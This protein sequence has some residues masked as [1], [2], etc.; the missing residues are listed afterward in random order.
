[1]LYGWDGAM[2]EAGGRGFD[3]G[4]FFV[5]GAHLVL[6]GLPIS[7]GNPLPVANRGCK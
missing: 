4:F 6:N 2:R 7:T 5:G 1:M 3:V